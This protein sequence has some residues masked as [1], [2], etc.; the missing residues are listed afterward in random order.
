MKKVYISPES[1]V[2]EIDTEVTLMA[3]SSNGTLPGTSDGG[4][5]E[6]GK[7]ADSQSRRDG[8]GDLWN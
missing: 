8:W 4:D 3:A 5:S 2:L 1:V 7:W 6:G